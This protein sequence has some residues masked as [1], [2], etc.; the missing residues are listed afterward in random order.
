MLSVGFQG[1][2]NIY[3]NNRNIVANN[4]NK[5]QNNVAFKGNIAADAFVLV[6]EAAP[7]A[8]SGEFKHIADVLK[9]LGV[10][11][12]ELGDNIDLARLLK[13]AMKRVKRLGYEVPTRIRCESEI[14]KKNSG[15][16]REASLA[17]NN[18]NV[19]KE[20]RKM[21]VPGA[22]GWNGINDPVMYLNTEYCWDK[23]MDGLLK[24]KDLRQN[25]WHETGH[26]LHMQNYRENPRA[27]Y[28]LHRIKLDSYQSGIVERSIG[29][30]AARN[31]VDETIAEIYT[32]LV[33]GEF[34]E[35]LHPEVFNIYSTYR[36]PMPRFRASSGG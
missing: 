25:I 34:Y 6:R 3:F 36:G 5:M 11:E 35:D 24:V 22:V 4:Q 19:K 29:L 28:N 26:W 8:R 9:T 17:L 23:E 14:F 12:L 21:I 30:Y 1:K 18:L 31:P 33:S 2:S 7:V 20:D 27:Y 15:I 13:S 32:K 16:Q 10:K